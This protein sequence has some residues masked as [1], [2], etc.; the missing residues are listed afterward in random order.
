MGTLAFVILASLY[1]HSDAANDYQMAA[2]LISIDSVFGIHLLRYL[3]EQ[4]T[5][6]S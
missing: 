1:G 4:R 6:K 3:K 5:A 2:L